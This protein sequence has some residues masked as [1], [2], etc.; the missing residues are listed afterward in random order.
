MCVEVVT[1]CH[2]HASDTFRLGDEPNTLFVLFL[3]HIVVVVFKV[4]VL[5]YEHLMGV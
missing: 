1:E 2:E 4:L 5:R 3:P